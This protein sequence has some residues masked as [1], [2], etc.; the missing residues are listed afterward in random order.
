MNGNKC[1]AILLITATLGLLYAP[2]VLADKTS[3]VIDAPDEAVTGSEITITVK[4]SHKGN[5]FMHHTNW[6]YVAV[7]GTEIKRWTYGNFS[8]PEGKEF[9]RT[10]TWTVDGPTEI[11]A[12][13]NCNIHG[14][15]G[16]ARKT[17]AVK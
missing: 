8:L 1:V 3:V 14:S 11:T 15:V 6:V 2:A 12:E 13:G 16:V 17:V 10:I 5:N 9:D 7:N 4:V